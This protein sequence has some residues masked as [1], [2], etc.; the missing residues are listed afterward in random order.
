MIRLAIIQTIFL[1]IVAIGIMNAQ[2][3]GFTRMDT[4]RISYD[5]GYSQGS[6]LADIDNDGDI[7]LTIG[8]SSGFAPPNQSL[9][10]Y[11]NERKGNFTRIKTGDLA[12]DYVPY[13]LQTA[14]LV[15][16]D[17]DGDW[18]ACMP[19]LFYMNNGY[20]EFTREYLDPGSGTGCGIPVVSW[21]DVNQDGHLDFFI[22]YQNM[23]NN[24]LY[25]SNGDGTY[26]EVLD[27][28]ITSTPSCTEAAS[29]ADY[30]NDGDMDLFCASF[31]F[32]GK[33]PDLDQN[34]CFINEGG[35]F[36]QM[37][38]SNSLVQ[39][40]Q[41]SL[42]G[43]WGDYD[44]DRDLDLYLV[45]ARG[46]NQL[47]QNDG[48]GNFTPLTIDPPDAQ[49]KC[50]T[51]SA[52]GDFDNDGDLDLFVTSEQNDID[53]VE[54]VVVAHF[55]MLL[56]NNGDG[57]FTEVASGN[58]K[59]DGGHSCALL[60]Y[61]NDGDLDIL[62]PNGSL[63]EPLVNYIY[64]NE[65]NGNN[66]IN[67][68]C[69]G[70]LSNASA[71][72]ARVYTKATIY[73]KAVWQMR[74]LAQ[75]T[76]LHSISSPRFHFG[77]GDAEMIDSIIILWPSGVEDIY[78]DVQAN[79]FMRAIEDST[80]E[81]DY[82]ATNYIEYGPIIESLKVGT[83][84][85]ATIDLND[86]FRLVSGDKVPEGAGEE[87]SYMLFDDPE[88]DLLTSSLDGSLLTLHGGSSTGNSSVKLKVSADMY[89][90]RIDEIVVRV[91]TPTGID[92][93]HAGRMVSVYPNP[94]YD[95][96]NVEFGQE[97]EGTTGIEIYDLSGRLCLVKKIEGG[98]PGASSISLAGLDKGLYF[99]CISNAVFVRT[100]K[101][102]KTD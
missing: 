98:N 86:Y 15:D 26:S 99:V 82:S 42:A 46:N 47:Y 50:F 37:D 10:V 30:D 29:W 23:Q 9:L 38:D 84:R 48:A 16:V 19:C 95:R 80:L 94:A 55:N 33:D 6:A 97:P 54:E 57:S 63:G 44:N 13:G 36:F 62:I 4:F 71:I 5:L 77:L 18:D 40:D 1:I 74:E 76:G 101:L 78:L 100:E 14:S 51:G 25:T 12:T 92:A 64:S 66:W 43:S 35:T 73:G 58:L 69:R 88:P 70:I 85:D 83:E 68:S 27:D 56:Q 7:D 20:G 93:T 45:T 61:D 81:V 72:G 3:P 102:L 8:N 60:D 39:Y 32:L 49:N 2:M 65:G 31:S 21:V 52:W 59:E 24:K 96:I 41:G 53:F 17:N 28:P 75:Q 89:R 11:K 22:W 87:I 79:Q 91:R 90:E 34:M 67:I